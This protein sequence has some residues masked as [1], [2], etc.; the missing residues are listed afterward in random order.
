[1]NGALE[2]PPEIRTFYVTGTGDPQFDC[3]ERCVDALL[4]NLPF[5]G[6]MDRCTRGLWVPKLTP[7]TLPKLP[8]AQAFGEAF[9]AV[10]KPLERL[11]ILA[12]IAG[13]VIIGFK[14]T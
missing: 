8:T 12:I 5:I 9:G 2:V 1:M 3:Q 14:V 6:C 4:T 10:T 11:L 13:I 7:I